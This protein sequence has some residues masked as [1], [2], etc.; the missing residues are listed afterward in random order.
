[1]Q[2]LHHK[3]LNK[4]LGIIPGLFTGLIVM[5]LIM[6]VIP[7]VDVPQTISDDF[8]PN[9]L[10]GFL[11][12][13][14]EW[15][16]NKLVPV[17]EKPF[18]QTIAAANEN[19]VSHEAVTLSFVTDVYNIRPDL[20]MQ[21][22]L[23]V[24]T[25]R[26]KNGLKP[27]LPDPQLTIVAREH[28]EDMFKRGYFAHNTPD[29]VDPFQ[30]MHNANIKYLAAGENLAFA[31]TLNLAH[32]GLMNSPGHRANILN[33]HYGKLGVGILDGGEYGLMITQEFRN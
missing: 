12:P 15:L 19:T 20:E 6:R 26:E 3:L 23:M 10:T 11:N 8:K 4:V 29:G 27:L 25:E 32:E 7:L 28:S 17:F 16:E 24:N 1:M 2:P 22:L 31:Q 9:E 13:A 33:P 5:T 14:E 30:R 21:L 18:T